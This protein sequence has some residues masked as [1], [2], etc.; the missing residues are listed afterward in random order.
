MVPII[1][2]VILKLF[3]SF[4][5]GAWTKFSLVN[6]VFYVGIDDK[7]VLSGL[8]CELV[9]GVVVDWKI[10]PV[11]KHHLIDYFDII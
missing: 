2:E 3:K 8:E 7:F 4:V 11:L 1:N 6:D 9:D 10:I 5:Y